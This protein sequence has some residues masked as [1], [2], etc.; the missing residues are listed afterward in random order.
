MGK[1]TWGA[2]ADLLTPSPDDSLSD[3]KGREKTCWYWANANCEYSAD[4]CR[5]LHKHVPAGVMPRPPDKKDYWKRGRK[6]AYVPAE[7]QDVSNGE[8]GDG[9]TD[10]MDQ[11]A[12]EFTW[13]D[14]STEKYK[15]PH[16]K[17][18]EEKEQ[19]KS[20]DWW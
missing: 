1:P 9:N 6:G 18:L 5:F 2:V 15:P 20:A 3:L 19:M 10:L 7:G 11:E 12:V 8:W 13:V 4:S 14:N 17:A 16:V